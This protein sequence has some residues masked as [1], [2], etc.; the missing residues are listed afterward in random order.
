MCQSGELTGRGAAERLGP[1]GDGAQPGGVTTEVRD[2]DQ[3]GVGDAGAE[4]PAGVTY[5]ARRLV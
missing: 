2:G 1:V 5:S 3:T 4:Y